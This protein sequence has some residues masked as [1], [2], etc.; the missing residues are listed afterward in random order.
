[1][2]PLISQFVTALDEEISALK[3]GK[4][5]S[6]SKVF[7]GSLIRKAPNGYVYLFH[8]ENFLAT[9]DDAPAEIEIKGQRHPAQ[10]LLTQGLEVEISIEAYCGDTVAEGKI[11]TNLW[12][13]LELLKKKFL[14]SANNS[15]KF[16]LSEALFSA[17][18]SR[19]HQDENDKK[20]RYSPSEEQ[21]NPAQEK[22]IE[23]SFSQPLSVIWGPPGTG[24]TTTIA[25]AIEAHLNAGRRVL[26]VSH[27]NNAVDQALL[28]VAE[29]MKNTD[30]YNNGELVRLGTPPDP[31]IFAQLEER[32]ELVLMDK[33]ANKLGASLVKE[34]NQLLEKKAQIQTEV[35]DLAVANDLLGILQTL[36]KELGIGEQGLRQ[37]A[38]QLNKTKQKVSLLKQT[39]RT[40]QNRL[41]EARSSGT[42]KR[43]FKG[44][45]PEKI[46]REIDKNSITLD[47]SQRQIDG[48]EEQVINL[49]KKHE[50]RAN[51]RSR[52]EE[53][54]GTMLRRLS[55][56][57]IE[58]L[59]E[60]NQMVSQGLQPIEKRIG[61]IDQSLNELQKNVLNKAR[62]VAT[63]LTK[64]FSDK[65]F[66]NLQ[67]D[68][69]DCGRG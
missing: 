33:I 26:L 64:T 9:L 54:F 20:L 8:L 67:F 60:K 49:Q 47:S 6:M 4:G 68:V 7:N 5:G 22:A 57:T 30:F 35:H 12:Y 10:I 46:Q 52:V 65:K 58:Q 37:I 2:T 29:Q 62:L 59:K 21:P 14:E 31:V 39:Q 28:D 53:E 32:Y 41:E 36:V 63:T 17:D 13:L 48:W 34:K 45:N 51:E 19:F 44:L 38:D 18:I 11:I 27:A 69:P 15:E 56:T 1:M 3:Q 66:D 50:D 24:K 61:E 23:S 55:I 16:K 25:K 43:I 42:L 40:N